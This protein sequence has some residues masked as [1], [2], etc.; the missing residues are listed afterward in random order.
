MLY[1]GK[2]SYKDLVFAE[3]D[4][5]RLVGSPN[6]FPNT[7]Y[8]ILSVQILSWYI[9]TFARVTMETKNYFKAYIWTKLVIRT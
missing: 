3:S 5:L 2:T 8:Y 1:F 7:Y 9:T 4:F 6:E